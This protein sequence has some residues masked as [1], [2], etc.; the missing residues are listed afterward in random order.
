MRPTPFPEPRPSWWVAILF[1]LVVAI[2]SLDL[3]AVFLTTWLSYPTP[4]ESADNT[5]AFDAYFRA[6]ESRE[7]L[8]IWCACAA[9]G[10]GAVVAAWSWRSSREV[11]Y[12]IALAAGV[13]LLSVT[14]SHV[15]ST[16]QDALNQAASGEV[17]SHLAD[18]AIKVF[19]IPWTALIGITA[20]LVLILTALY[21]DRPP[22]SLVQRRILLLP[23][24]SRAALLSEPRPSWLITMAFALVCALFLGLIGHIY[25]T[26]YEN[27]LPP[28][29]VDAVSPPH[30]REVAGI[31]GWAAAATGAAL[32]VWVCRSPRERRFHIAFLSGFTCLF[33][34]AVEAYHSRDEFLRIGYF[35]DWLPPFGTMSLTLHGPALTWLTATLGLVL[36]L[37]AMIQDRR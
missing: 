13:G 26:I 19:Q 11:R 23:R 16:M 7:N 8:M 27:T 33:I 28:V 1:A 24:Q 17:Q 21:L 15:R 29:F 31:F 18:E 2:F 3:T 14:F 22:R 20:G 30:L 10:L 5:A 4:P 34:A 12:H 36:I 37:G 9:G 35:Q 6:Q 25:G 32:A